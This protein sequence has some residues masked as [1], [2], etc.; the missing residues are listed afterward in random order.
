ME[1]TLS[2]IFTLV[3]L[4]AFSGCDY[5]DDSLIV[6]TALSFPPY[7]YVENGK[8]VG[9][10][11]DIV[12]EI[13]QRMN[14]KIEIESMDF[15]DLFIALDYNKIDI[16]AAGLSVT[17]KRKETMDFTVSYATG[18][19]R[20]LVNKNTDIHNIEELKNANILIGVENGTTGH[21]LALNLFESSYIR[22]YDDATRMIDALSSGIVSA[23]VVDA[24]P[25]EVF[26]ERYPYLEIIDPMADFEEYALALDKDS[27]YYEDVNNVLQEMINDG[28]VDEIMK[29]YAH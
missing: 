10:D 23:A 27:E 11:I 20:I 18:E 13:G 17:E 3:I 6:G 21:E 12:E 8:I 4:L 22:D 7:E 2:I 26:V 9:I 29:K 1:K 19:Q 16:I 5:N 15:D 25:A 14:K 28:T 24:A